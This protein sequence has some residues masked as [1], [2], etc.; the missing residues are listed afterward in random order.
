MECPGAMVARR[1][2][3][4][5]RWATAPRSR[6]V[7]H[8]ASHLR[9][10]LREGAWLIS[11]RPRRCIKPLAASTRIPE[12]LSG[13]GGFAG[14]VP[15]KGL[16]APS[17]SP[18]RWRWAPS[19]R[20]RLPRASR[21]IGIDSWPWRQRGHHQGASRSSFSIIR[22]GSSREVA[23]RYQGIDEGCVRRAVRVGGENAEFPAV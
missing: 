12:V 6:N 23:E 5:I 22:L 13:V 16:E 15:T 19:S 1:V 18:A 17:W 2:L 14:F 21:R 10:H 8:D 20:S 4:V 11:R 9:P 3:R 7:A